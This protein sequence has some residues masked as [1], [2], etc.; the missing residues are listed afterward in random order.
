MQGR[1]DFW[2]DRGGTFTD[3]IGRR[4]D[5]TLVAHKLLSENPEAYRD[6]A[7]AGH[8]PSARPCA[9]RA[10]PGGAHRRREDGH[11]GRHQ[12][13]ARAQGRAH[14]AADHQRLSRRAAHRLP[15][16]AENF[17]AATS[18]SRTCC[19]SASS[20][21]T[22]A[23]APTARSSARSISTRVRAELERAQADG[24]APSRSCSCTPIAIRDH[25]QRVAALARELGFAQVSAS[26]EVSPLIK[27]VGRGDTTVVDALSVADPAP[28]RGAGGGGLLES[29]PP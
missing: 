29:L 19:T 27:L 12:R 23:C 25:E 28:L 20:R 26:H 1:W 10:D 24:I 18:S 4:P 8:P 11:H 15:G 7:V 14:A 9:R 3:V 22:S 2:I 13:A 16:A 5:G 6:A 21:S 17:R